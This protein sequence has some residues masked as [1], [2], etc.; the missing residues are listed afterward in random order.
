MLRSS[1]F[2]RP[3]RRLYLTPAR[4]DLYWRAVLDG[5]LFLETAEFITGEIL[6]VDGGQSL[7]H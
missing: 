2:L 6:H 1:V 3:L 4:G 7:G 5:L